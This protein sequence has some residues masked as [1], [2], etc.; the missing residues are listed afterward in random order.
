MQYSDPELQPQTLA[1][2]VVFKELSLFSLP[3][4]GRAGGSWGT[5]GVPGSS[6]LQP[7][8]ARI[9]LHAQE[10]ARVYAG[11]G[12]GEVALNRW[13]LKTLV[14]WYMWGIGPSQM[15]GGFLLS[16]SFHLV[17]KYHGGSLELVRR[18]RRSRTQEWRWGR[19]WVGWAQISRGL[20]GLTPAEN[21][22]RFPGKGSSI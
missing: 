11:V 8:S 21:E 1:T 4:G 18:G 14:T 19:N 3:V 7:G 16:E 20:L 13:H 9:K 12:V 5:V 22:I 6:W 15:D 10:L 17:R 2:C